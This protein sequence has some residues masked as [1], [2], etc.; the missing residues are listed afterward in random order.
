MR[1]LTDK[2]IITK[3]EKKKKIARFRDGLLM[4]P[5]LKAC[6]NKDKALIRLTP[7]EHNHN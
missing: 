4:M 6:K 7:R 3:S 1:E 5:R 2:F